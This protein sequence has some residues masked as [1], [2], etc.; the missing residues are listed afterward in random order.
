MLISATASNEPQVVLSSGQFWTV[1]SAQ[2]RSASSRTHPASSFVPLPRST[3][4]GLFGGHLWCGN[5]LPLINV[6]RVARDLWETEPM[7]RIVFTE[8][9]V[10]IIRNFSH[11]RAILPDGRGTRAQ[12]VPDGVMVELLTGSREE[13]ELRCIFPDVSSKQ[14]K[15]RRTRLALSCS[16]WI[17]L[18]WVLRSFLV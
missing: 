2:S 1:R 4:D 10:Q 3:A 14:K 12:K 6:P 5:E 11:F 18:G 17:L 15:A 8:N 13:R 16:A 7:A 9:G